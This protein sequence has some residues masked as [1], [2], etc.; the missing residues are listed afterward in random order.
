MRLILVLSAA[1]LGAC[2]SP[3]DRCLR[4]AQAPLVELDAQISESE[5]ARARGYRIMPATEAR[6]TV[7][8][9]AWPKEPVLFCTRHTP[10]TRETR[11]VVEAGSEQANLDRLRAERRAVA[12]ETAQRVASCNAV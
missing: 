7:H 10:A 2:A 5:Q 12:E 1:L 9:C 8:I 6:T 4:Q 11:V 3:Q